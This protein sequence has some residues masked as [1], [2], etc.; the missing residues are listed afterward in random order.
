MGQLCRGGR[1]VN[2]S[3]P[4]NGRTVSLLGPGGYSGCFRAEHV[5]RQLALALRLLFPD[6]AAFCR[7]LRQAYQEA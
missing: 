5:F 2:V 6:E 4:A 1:R 3:R 7:R